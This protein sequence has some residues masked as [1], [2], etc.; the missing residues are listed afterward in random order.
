M[1][2]DVRRCEKMWEDMRRCEK[3]WEDVRRCEKM[4]EDVRRCE[5]MRRRWED[6]KMWRWEDV[7][8]RRC[9]DVKMRRCEDER[10]WEDVKM[11]R[12][13]DEKMWRWEDVKM[14]RCEDERMWRWEDVKMRRCEDE[15]MFYRPPLLEEPC[16]QTLSGTIP[17]RQAHHQLS[18]FC[19]WEAS[20]SHSHRSTADASS[21]HVQDV[22]TTITP[23]N[24]LYTPHF[25]SQ[26]TS[27]PGPFHL[28]PR[29]GRVFYI[30]T[31]RPH[32]SRTCQPVEAISTTTPACK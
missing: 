3:M 5:K 11:R 13:E 16:A 23:A 2:E 17:C 12:C 6:E 27:R 24:F 31:S 1:W 9:E 18:W 21:L 26:C 19:F 32:P 7:K 22:W 10:M 30:H 14:R 25:L 15:K 8:M 29:F 4:W 28:Q 20:Q